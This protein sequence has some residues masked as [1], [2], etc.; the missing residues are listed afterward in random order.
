MDNV[1]ATVLFISIGVFLLTVV[2]QLGDLLLDGHL[3][4]LVQ[5]LLVVLLSVVKNHDRLVDFLLD[6]VWFSFGLSNVVF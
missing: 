5:H 4:L 3:M 2:L 6:Q 1:A